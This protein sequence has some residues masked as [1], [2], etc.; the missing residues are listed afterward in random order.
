M[1]MTINQ[2][3]AGVIVAK[4]I[5]LRSEKIK[6]SRM[7][8]M[9]LPTPTCHRLGIRSVSLKP[10][11]TAMASVKQERAMPAS[12]QCAATSHSALTKASTMTVPNM[13][14][15]E[16]EA[17]NNIVQ[18]MGPP[19]SN[20]CAAI[21]ATSFLTTSSNSS[22]PPN[23]VLSLPS[24]KSRSDSTSHP[25]MSIRNPRSC[26]NNIFRSS[27]CHWQNFHKTKPGIKCTPKKKKPKYVQNLQGTIHNSGMFSRTQDACI[28]ESKRVGPKTAKTTHAKK[29]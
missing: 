7:G 16:R 9:S 13:K 4:T 22:T 1:G 18:G 27:M 29:W 6:P 15:W 21:W 2:G 3:A 19:S 12:T 20:C 11:P 14:M 24:M 23:Q 28:S 8:P 5:P 17:V 26:C 10:A 25:A